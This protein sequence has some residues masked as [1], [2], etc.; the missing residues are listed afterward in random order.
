MQEHKEKEH[1]DDKPAVAWMFLGHVDLIEK[2][3]VRVSGVRY[4][5]SCIKD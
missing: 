5:V 1:G 3:F 4:L 2:R